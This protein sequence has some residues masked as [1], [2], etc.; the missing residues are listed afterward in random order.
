MPIKR[1]EVKAKAKIEAE[2]IFMKMNP[3]MA[4]KDGT[5]PKASPMMP[6]AYNKEAKRV[7]RQVVRTRLKQARG[8]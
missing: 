6:R 8:K 1:K 2:K 3:Q 4:M 5:F 7:T